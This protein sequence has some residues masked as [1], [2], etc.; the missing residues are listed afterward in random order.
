MLL[1]LLSAAFIL[2]PVLVSVHALTV[3]APTRQ[4]QVA[5]GKDVTLRCNFKS[6]SVRDRGDLVVW[7]KIN[8]KVN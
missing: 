6:N 8:S 4:I 5:R 3:E 2:F 7:K 1:F